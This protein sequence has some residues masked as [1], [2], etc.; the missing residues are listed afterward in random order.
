MSRTGEPEPASASALARALDRLRAGEDFKPVTE[1]LL[2]DLEPRAAE[3]LM[4]WIKE[5][6]GAWLPLLEGRSGRA[7]FVGNGFSGTPIPIQSAGYE[8]TVLDPIP[9]RAAFAMRRLRC[10]EPRGRAS[11]IAADPV[12]GLPFRDRSFDLVV[13]EEPSAG[14]TLPS[15]EELAR[16]CA[17][18]LVLCTDN[19]LGYKRSR[20]LR[21]K[22]AIPTPWR[23][24][25]QVVSPRR[26]E[27]TLAGY[28]RAF[29]RL[30]AHTRA[31]A[32]YPHA[33]EF[34]HVVA[35]DSKRPRLTI[36]PRERRNLA[37]MAAY[38]LGLFPVFAPSFA[39]IGRRNSG[40]VGKGLEPR[41]KGVLA[42]LAE[43]LAEP[44]PRVDLVVA[45]RSDTCLV[46]TEC[47]DRAE[48]DPHGR[49]TLHVPLSPRKRTLVSTHHAFLKRVRE[50]FPRVPVP[51]PLFQGELEGLWLGCERRLPG[52]TAPHFTGKREIT[53]RFFLDVA[54]RFASLSLA[55]A[56]PFTDRDFDQHITSRFELVLR[57]AGEDSTRLALE[58]MLPRVRERLVGQPLP[59]VLHHGDLRGK[60]LQV[61]ASGRVLGV[62]D[63]GASEERFL[64]YHDLL[65]LVGH[66]RKQ[67][68]DCPA[69]FIWSLIQEPDRMRTH[70]RDALENYAGRLGLS[71]EVRSALA[72]AYPVLVTAMAER[73]WAWSRPRWIKRQYGV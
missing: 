39:I 61:D 30:F 26:G 20:G 60:H 5:G 33:R 40:S 70:E 37:K 27:Q 24:L 53:A 22:F 47:P 73:N 19:R 10:F 2:L 14:A 52:L 28:R 12:R 38:S 67:E 34:S 7:L 11:A 69:T 59:F 16:V 56:R 8:V 68:E 13:Y 54:E 6:R 55:P 64:P 62:L 63:W 4:L 36:G 31:F 3:T 25:S 44:T 51:E 50:N 46:H 15:T 23:Y 21:G 29:R 35:L 43:R 72:L 32:L 58:R 48:D 42:A 57:H 17:G 1:Q 66:Q 9:E 18:E 45:T 41:I 49:W 65:H 71:Q